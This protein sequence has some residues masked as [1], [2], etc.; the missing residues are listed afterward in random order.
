VKKIFSILVTAVLIL[1]CGCDKIHNPTALTEKISF[2]AEIDYNN[3][4]YELK[5]KIPKNSNIIIEMD[6]PERLKGS[7]FEFSNSNLTFNSQ[8]L[9]YKTSAENLPSVSPVGF[10]YYVF[11]DVAKKSDQVNFQNDE[12]FIS[13]KIKNYNYKFSFGAS[14]LPIKIIDN[15]NNIT[16]FIKGVSIDSIAF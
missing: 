13:G 11:S 1:L 10:I 15:K 5:V 2:N 12:Y 8:G 4:K 7:I 14:G 6:S 9:S 16:A 3:E